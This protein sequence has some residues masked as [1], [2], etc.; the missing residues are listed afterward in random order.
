MARVDV[1]EP[2]K[3]LVFVDDRDTEA[4]VTFEASD[5]GTRV[6]LEHRGLERLAPQD[7]EHHARFG[8]RLVF[9]WYEEYITTLHRSDPTCEEEPHDRHEPA[10]VPYLYYEDGVAALEFLAR[11]VRLPG[12]HAARRP[13]RRR[14]GTARCSSAPRSSCSPRC[15]TRL[16]TSSARATAG[17]YVTVDD[18]DAHC[19]RARAAGATIESEPEDKPYG[20]RMYGVRDPSGHQWWFAQPIA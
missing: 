9:G 13:G 1:W 15:R 10:S 12:T 6:T 18:V 14:C 8:W 7:A 17:I 3:R 16:P 4:D 2:G 19:E 20:A 11:R 5:G